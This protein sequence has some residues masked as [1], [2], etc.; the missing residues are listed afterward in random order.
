MRDDLD[1]SESFTWIMYLKILFIS[2]LI[3][4]WNDGHPSQMAAEHNN[5]CN[6][7]DFSVRQV[8]TER[9]KWDLFTLQLRRECKGTNLS[10]V[11]KIIE[12]Q[13]YVCIYIY[14]YAIRL[15]VY[16]LTSAESLSSQNW[17]SAATPSPNFVFRC[18][19]HKFLPRLVGR[20]LIWTFY[21]RTGV[22]LPCLAWRQ[23]G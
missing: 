18:L 22:T 9:E 8:Q 7:D 16:L 10:F 12:A 13:L 17:P 5:L 6:P 3:H 23:P 21:V 15:T 2:S 14:T 1:L 20:P 4:S 19:C 11:V